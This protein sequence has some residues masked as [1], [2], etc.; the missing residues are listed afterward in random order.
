MADTLHAHD[1]SDHSL[2]DKKINLTVSADDVELFV[3]SDLFLFKIE[4]T[5]GEDKMC[6]RD[7]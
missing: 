6:P 4:V 3:S 2:F 1:S 5:R 7:E